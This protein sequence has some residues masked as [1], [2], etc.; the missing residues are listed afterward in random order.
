M[1]ASSPLSAMK[2]NYSDDASWG[3]DGGCTDHGADGHFALLLV[4]LPYP[5]LTMADKGPQAAPAA[6][7]SA[8]D[9]GASSNYNGRRASG[10]NGN[11][12][13]DTR[14]CTGDYSDYQRKGY[15]S[16]DS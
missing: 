13:N 12:N 4:L 2:I 9:Y 5:G 15:E 7:S 1:S 10:N 3:Y 14:D 6:P 16:Q 11:D 8:D